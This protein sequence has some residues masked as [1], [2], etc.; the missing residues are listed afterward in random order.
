MV[1]NV[2]PDGEYNW[3]RYRLRLIHARC[4]GRKDARFFLLVE[5]K[6]IVK[7]LDVYGCN[8][9]FPSDCLK[10]FGWNKSDA[11]RQKCQTKEITMR[12]M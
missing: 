4:A 8:H 12:K 9:R 3:E 6:T 7:R 2:A 5:A 1:P 11:Y 10:N